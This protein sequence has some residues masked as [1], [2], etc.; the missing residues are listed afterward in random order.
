MTKPI[1]SNDFRKRL[2]L[3]IDRV[4]SLAVAV[5]GL[6]VLAPLFALISL[7]IKLDSPGPLFFVQERLGL[8]GRRFKLVKFRVHDNHER[9]RSLGRVLREFRLDELPLFIN[10][11]RG[12]ISL[13]DMNR[14]GP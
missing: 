12:D 3:A 4:T 8:H 1:L 9:I 11:I 6:I 5:F 2:D 7:L 10:V 13:W 14:F